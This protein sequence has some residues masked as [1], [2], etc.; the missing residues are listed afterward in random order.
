MSGV[1]SKGLHFHMAGLGSVTQGAFVQRPLTIFCGPNNTGKTWALYAL[2]H[3]LTSLPRAKHGEESEPLELE[4]FNDRVSR[5]LH[6]LFNGEPAH[7]ANAS[8]HIEDTAGWRDILRSPDSRPDVFLIPAERNGLH[9]FY[10]EL[11]TRRTALLHHASKPS[12]DIV[13]L[14]KDV[15]RSRYSAPIARYI[16]WL[17][18]LTD[19]KKR[20]SAEFHP[21]AEKLKKSI[22]RGSYRVRPDTGEVT[23]SP[24]KR[25]GSGEKVIG[26]PSPMD[27]H[28]TSSTVKSLFGL[29]FYLEHQAEKGDVLMLDEPELNVHPL[30]QMRIARLLAQLVNAGLNVVISTHSDYIVRELNTQI[31]LHDE[32]AGELRRKHGY[33]DDEVLDAKDVGAY[34]FDSQTIA[35]F[36]VTPESGIHA[37]TFDET[38]DNL[39]NTGDD[40]YYSL[41]EMESPESNAVNI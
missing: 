25:R 4:M 30:N 1:V 27:L 38:I 28:L 11:S 17:N 26:K 7:F 37:T 23:F 20:R 36:S 12:I 8:F 29:W 3:F 13:E 24:Y 34:L 2:F 41:L 22:A 18:S 32:R 10:R 15:I 39:N 6:T 21:L 35:P 9:L 19:L 33:E 40:I 5:S 16:D 31:M 14:L